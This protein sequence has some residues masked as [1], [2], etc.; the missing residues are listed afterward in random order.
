MET[1]MKC[2]VMDV[3]LS[4]VMLYYFVWVT[5]ECGKLITAEDTMNGFLKTIFSFKSLF[6]QKHECDWV[7]LYPE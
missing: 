5:H 1:R 2:Y 4:Y 7:V 3:M 6:I